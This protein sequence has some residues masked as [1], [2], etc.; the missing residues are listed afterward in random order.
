MYLKSLTRKSPRETPGRLNAPSLQGA[1]LAKGLGY[2]S[3]EYL[4]EDSVS[5]SLD[6]TTFRM[7]DIYWI[8]SYIAP[9]FS[10]CGTLKEL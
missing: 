5:A 6:V 10:L 2:Q 9:D 4:L 7:T 1:T 3:I 8:I